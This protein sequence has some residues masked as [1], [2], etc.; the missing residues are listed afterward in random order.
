MN[1]LGVKY[2]NGRGVPQNYTEAARWY[3]KAAEQGNIPVMYTFGVMYRL[4][5]GVP[6]PNEPHQAERNS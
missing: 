3:H 4:G 1:T 6:Q 5:R 2:G